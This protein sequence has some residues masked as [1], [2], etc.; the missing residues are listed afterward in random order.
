MYIKRT[1]QIKFPA[2]YNGNLSSPRYEYEKSKQ[3]YKFKRNVFKPKK[4]NEEFSLLDSMANDDI[5]LLGLLVFLY[6][7]CEHTKENLLLI[8]IL[9]YLLLESKLK[10]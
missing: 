9:G 1:P 5:L 4:Q 10:L 3:I 6:V 8:G 7:G 2:N